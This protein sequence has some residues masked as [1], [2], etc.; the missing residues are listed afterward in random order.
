MVQILPGD[1]RLLTM[2]RACNPQKLAEHSIYDIVGKIDNLGYL[3]K[4]QPL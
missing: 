4:V 2:P 1:I 3:L